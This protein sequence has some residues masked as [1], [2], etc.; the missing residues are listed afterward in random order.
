MHRNNIINKINRSKKIKP[1]LH[2]KKT[3]ILKEV[4]NNGYTKNKQPKTN[5]KQHNK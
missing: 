4:K 2:N 1:P 5:D 3:K